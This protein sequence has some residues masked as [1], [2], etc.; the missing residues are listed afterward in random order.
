VKKNAKLTCFIVLCL[1]AVLY[2][3]PS[4]SADVAKPEWVSGDKWV[5]TSSVYGILTTTTLEYD[6][7]ETLTVNETSYDVYVIK[8]DETTSAYGLNLTYL[9]QVYYQRSDMGMVKT[10]QS[11]ELLGMNSNIATYAPP[12]KDSKFPLSVGQTWTETYTEISISTFNGEIFT[13]EEKPSTATYTVLLQEEITVAAGTFDTYKIECDGG[14]AGRTYSWYAPEVK[15]YVKMSGGGVTTQLSSYEVTAPQTSGNGDPQEIGEEG[16]GEFDLFAMPYLL[17]LILIPV[18]VAVLAV[19]LVA[20]K[21]KKK[22]TQAQVASQP[23]VDF[24][25]QGAPAAQPQYTQATAQPR[26]TQQPVQQTAQPRYTQAPQRTAPARKAPPK[27]TQATRASQ[28][29]APARKAPP[30]RSQTPTAQAPQRTAPA[31]KAP[32]R[33][34]PARPPAKRATPKQTQTQPARPPSHPR[35]TPKTQPVRPPPSQA[36]PKQVA[37]AQKQMPPPPPPPPA[38]VVHPCPTCKQPLDLIKQYN[39]WYCRNC[40][41]YP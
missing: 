26:Y 1:F 12:K 20:M 34:A 24:S 25:V 4:A 3:V 17:F 33:T 2:I 7:V 35:P 27:Q 15:N 8:K 21:R 23:T 19:G 13:Y 22:K 38:P 41:K 5:Y 9:G 16:G 11:W 10:N 28:R 39:R 32:Q 29:T 18:I 36:P 31:R 37:P 30:K 6:G 40:K 14:G